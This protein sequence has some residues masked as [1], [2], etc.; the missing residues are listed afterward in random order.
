MN[1]CFNFPLKRYEH[2]PFGLPASPRISPKE[3]HRK[4][5][6]VHH[7]PFD[8]GFGAFLKKGGTPLLSKIMCI[9]NGMYMLIYVY[10]YMFMCIY[11]Y[12]YVNILYMTYEVWMFLKSWG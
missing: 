7:D 1:F 6:G 12:D 11:I 8:G 2:V 9:W 5:G 3:D 10:I 4:A